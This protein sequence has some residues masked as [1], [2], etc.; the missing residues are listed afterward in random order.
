MGSMKACAWWL[1]K[2]WK[3]VGS[4]TSK[5]PS[6]SGM[7]W[8]RLTWYPMCRDSTGWPRLTTVRIPEGVDDMQVRKRLLEEYNIEVAGGFGEL[9][10]V[11]WRIGFMGYSSRQENV[12]LLLKALEGL[13]L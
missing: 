9:K 4:D 1:R 3:L 2:V 8:R 11:V 5:T 7:G 6:C 12:N 13:V 10:G